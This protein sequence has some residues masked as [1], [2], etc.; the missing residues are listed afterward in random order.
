MQDPCIRKRS[1]CS[2]AVSEDSFG[3]A[4]SEK[5]E[6]ITLRSLK[7]DRRRRRRQSVAQQNRTWWPAGTLGLLRACYL[8]VF[9][10]LWQR[11]TVMF[12]APRILHEE[13]FGGYFLD[14][15]A[16]RAL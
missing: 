5:T 16:V 10:L 14:W 13:S 15:A 12:T 2:R 6:K 3:G 9:S 11:C 8:T 7:I 1:L 4:F